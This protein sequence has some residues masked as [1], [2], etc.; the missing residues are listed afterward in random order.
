MKTNKQVHLMIEKLEK[1]KLS[2]PQFS[3]FGDNNHEAID[4]AIEV[5][6]ERL[7]FDDVYDKELESNIELM[8]TT[9]VEW[10]NG[11]IDDD[12]LLI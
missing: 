11:D 2:I 8:G 12:E 7:D 9:A 3:M 1:L 10:L 5:L 6:N 4:F